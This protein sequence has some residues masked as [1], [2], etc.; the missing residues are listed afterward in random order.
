MFLGVAV[1]V[2]A[3]V[4]IK[5][6]EFGFISLHMLH[7]SSRTLARGVFTSPTSMASYERG[8]GWS[9]NDFSPVLQARTGF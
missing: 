2:L 3:N 6:I 1:Q 7:P 9:F 4:V 5:I 8:S